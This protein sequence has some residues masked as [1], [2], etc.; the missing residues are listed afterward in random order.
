M[1]RP[2]ASSR[3]NSSQ[4][5][6]SGTSSELAIS[7]RGANGWVG[8][9]ATGLPDCTSRVSS[10]ARSTSVALMAARLAGSRAALPR[11]P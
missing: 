2:M 8:K 3:Q 10:A 4:V 11:P 6:H 1:V 5:A 7:T 9:T